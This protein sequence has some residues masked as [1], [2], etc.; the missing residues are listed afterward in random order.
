M[1]RNAKVF[2]LD[3]LLPERFGGKVGRGLVPE[4]FLRLGELPESGRSAKWK[5]GH[6]PW[7]SL[8]GYEEG[9]SC[10]PASCTSGGH[11]L[12]D[13]SDRLQKQFVMLVGLSGRTAY[14]IGG[15]VVGVG[16]DEEPVLRNAYFHEALNPLRLVATKMPSWTVEAWN[17]ARMPASMATAARGHFRAVF[18]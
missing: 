1:I 12:L 7:V 16:G 11:I 10:F 14:L 6:T 15:E 3:R 17:A 18:G 2:A 4:C 9:V 8:R 5:D 13:L